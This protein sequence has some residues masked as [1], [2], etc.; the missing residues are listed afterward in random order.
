MPW[1]VSSSDN[2]VI[3]YFKNFGNRMFYYPQYVVYDTLAGT[4][5]TMALDMTPFNDY[6]EDIADA[7]PLDDTRAR[8]LQ[9]GMTYAVVNNGVKAFKRTY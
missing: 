6:V 4:A 5:M 8:Q 7:M 1:T 3:R 9:A 2:G